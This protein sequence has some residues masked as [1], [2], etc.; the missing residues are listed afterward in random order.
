MPLILHGC[1]VSLLHIP[2][3]NLIVTVNQIA[4]C[5]WPEMAHSDNT[6]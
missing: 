5:Q 2:C 1:L 6:E 3:A 4:W